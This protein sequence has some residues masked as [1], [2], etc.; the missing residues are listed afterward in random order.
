MKSPGA[1]VRFA[2]C[3]AALAVAGVRAASSGPEPGA[4]EFALVGDYN[5][6]PVGDPEW[7]ES[8]RMIAAVN[9]SRARFAVHLGDIK[10]GHAECTDAVYAANRAQF[11]EFRMPLVYL[12]GDN[13]WT[14]CHRYA[15][16]DPRSPFVD[17]LE[18]L[19]K[20]RR[21][22]YPGTS[23]QGGGRLRLE[24]QADAAREPRFRRFVENA[25]WEL[26]GVL[27]VGANV[28]GGNNHYSGGPGSPQRVK[29]P[30]QDAEWALRN[31]A[32]IDW[33]RDSFRRAARR[34]DRAV[35]VAW[36]A[37]PDFEQRR[38]EL[39]FYDSDGYRELV[40]ALQE[41]AAAFPGPVVLAH[42]DSHKGFRTDHPLPLPNFAR[43]ENYGDPH[44]HWTRVTVL[45][46]RQGLE[47]FRFEGMH[48]QGNP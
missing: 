31:A 35:F 11:A 17:P 2:A 8:E 1:R 22:F 5:Y 32:V 46:D 23:A 24:R 37:N 26:G 28:P 14:D 36:Q 47:M 27:F 38:P 3:A 19:A 29:V 48:V 18:R 30:G 4:F 16:T 20:L 41:Q 12:F 34:G 42:G 45:P 39:P 15:A 33:L 44:T 21:M 6:G 13:E 10:A 40:A 7:R 9:A 25:R 43:V